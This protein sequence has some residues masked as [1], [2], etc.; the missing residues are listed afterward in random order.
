MRTFSNVLAVGSVL[1]KRC[2][3]AVKLECGFLQKWWYFKMAY[4]RGVFSENSKIELN[5][6]CHEA[7]LQSWYI[8][9]M[10]SHIRDRSNFFFR[11]SFDTDPQVGFQLVFHSLF[12]HSL[13]FIH[14]S[15]LPDISCFALCWCSLGNSCFPRF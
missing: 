5:S 14:I 6:L 10:L 4:S 2:S 11:S 3:F 7:E 12:S 8:P 1:K 9:K 13:T 15:S